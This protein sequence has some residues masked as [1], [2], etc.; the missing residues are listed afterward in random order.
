MDTGNAAN[1][2]R[3]LGFR[4]AE[5]HADAA[6]VGGCHQCSGLDGWS[7]EE[8]DAYNSARERLVALLPKPESPAQETLQCVDG[9]LSVPPLLIPPLFM[10]R[11]GGSHKNA[12]VSPPDLKQYDMVI[13]V[14]GGCTLNPGTIAAA[15]V[16]AYKLRA[17]AVYES[18]AVT[19]FVSTR[20]T[21][22]IMVYHIESITKWIG[23]VG[24]AP[25]Q[26][27]TNSLLCC[28]PYYV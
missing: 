7:L 28:K 22:N 11:R 8:D 17:G 12:P 2:R 14:D 15:A 6:F 24:Y 5:H 18:A 10:P 1:V 25:P 27:Y 19:S 9:L 4:S 13:F 26:S 16:V 20:T 23:G 21:N 3:G